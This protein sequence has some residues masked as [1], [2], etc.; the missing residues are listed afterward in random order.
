MRTTTLRGVVLAA[1]LAVAVS[2]ALVATLGAHARPTQAGSAA[3]AAGLS[4]AHEASWVHGKLQDPPAI[5]AQMATLNGALDVCLTSHGAPRVAIA[6]GGWTYQDPNGVAQAACKS[7]QDAVNTFA[8]GPEM[9]G[10]SQGIQPLMNAFWS[11]MYRT[12]V[13]SKNPDVMVDLQSAAVKAGEDACSVEANTA[14][15]SR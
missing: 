5:A 13:V 6:G 15:A 3:F 12:G 9:A 8:D 2:V 4:L 14:F 1:V 7:Q 11:C 10:E